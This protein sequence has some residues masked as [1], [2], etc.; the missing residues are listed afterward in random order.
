MNEPL[1]GIDNLDGYI[2]LGIVLLFSLI[3]TFAGFL[4]ASK[5]T[6]SDWIQEAGGFLVLSF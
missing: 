6:F 1:L 4:T 5:R 2:V 3:E